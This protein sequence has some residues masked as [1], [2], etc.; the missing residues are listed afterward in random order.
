MDFK[1]DIHFYLTELDFADIQPDILS[2][3]E[4]LDLKSDE[5]FE[6]AILISLFSDRRATPEEATKLKEYLGGWFGDDLRGFRIGSKLW[7]LGREKSLQ[8]V[9]PLL[10]QYTKEA[11][12]WMTKDGI[13]NEIQVKAERTDP[14]TFTIKVFVI[15]STGQNTFFR[16]FYNWKQQMFGGL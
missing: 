5:G 1:G 13:A 15:G 11:L 3:N 7:T 4:V 12:D 14:K 6:T 10:E 9:I 8:N 2:N 16:Y